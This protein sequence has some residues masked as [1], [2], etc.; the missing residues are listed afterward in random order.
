MVRSVLRIQYRQ[1]ESEN[2][3]LGYQVQQIEIILDAFHLKFRNSTALCILTAKSVLHF[4][5]PITLRVQG[6]RKHGHFKS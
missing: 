5:N 4:S 2:L 3:C 6:E 1:L